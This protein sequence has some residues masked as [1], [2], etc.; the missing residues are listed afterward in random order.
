VLLKVV[1]LLLEV[2]L[3]NFKTPI[4]M[5]RMRRPSATIVRSARGIALLS[6]SA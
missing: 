3:I 4:A 1:Y 6:T 2:P 5:L